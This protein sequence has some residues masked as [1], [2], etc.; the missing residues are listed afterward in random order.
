MV[1]KVTYSVQVV[2][3]VFVSEGG[4]NAR[5]RVVSSS[6]RLHIKVEEGGG[7]LLLYRYGDRSA[8]DNVLHVNAYLKMNHGKL[9]FPFSRFRHSEAM[10]RHQWI[11]HDHKRSD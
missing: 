4:E 10:I 6:V 9:V 5:L 11:E 3:Y 2:Y 7:N 1:H 8:A